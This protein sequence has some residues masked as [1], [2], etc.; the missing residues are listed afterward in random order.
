METIK[1]TTHK[2]FC[3]LIELLEMLE[4]D[5]KISFEFTDSLEAIENKII[6]I[7]I[8]EDRE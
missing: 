2:T 8:G 1:T 3:K 6:N 5:D 7:Y 4:E